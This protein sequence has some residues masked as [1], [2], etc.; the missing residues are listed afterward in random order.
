LLCVGGVHDGESGCGSCSLRREFR[1]LELELREAARE[2]EGKC[3]GL[4]CCAAVQSRE[5]GV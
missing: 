2:R 3:D 4:S 1:E 5:R